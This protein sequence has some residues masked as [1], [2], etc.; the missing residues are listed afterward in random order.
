MPYCW[1][2][3]NSRYS[4]ILKTIKLTE[5]ISDSFWMHETQSA[6]NHEIKIGQFIQTSSVRP[7]TPKGFAVQCINKS[8][9]TIGL[10]F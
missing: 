10:K 2:R 9:K 4:E 1:H 3:A 7:T 8:T 5:N 6:I